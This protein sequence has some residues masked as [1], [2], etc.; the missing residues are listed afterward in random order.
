L[1]KLRL[2]LTAD[3]KNQN[4]HDWLVLDQSGRLIRQGK[5][6]LSELPVC[7]ETEV[8]IPTHLVNFINVNLP[9]ATG[10]KLD[11][12][13]PFIVEE[14]ILSN[15]D[16]VHVIIGSRN[17]DRATL[18]IVQKFWMKEFMA[19]LSSAKIQVKRMFPDCL[20][21]SLRND[22]WT[23]AQQETTLLVRTGQID[24]FALNLANSDV[25]VAYNFLQMALKEKNQPTKSI[26][27][28]AYGELSETL[29]EWESNL[30]A[31][32]GEMIEGE[33]RSNKLLAPLNLLQKDFLGSNDFVQR[34]YHFKGCA[35]LAIFILILHFCFTLVEVGLQY[36][37]V[38]QIN[39][40]M[41]S[42]FKSSFPDTTAIVDAPLQMQRKL[43]EANHALGEVSNSD[44]QP[45]LA[46]ISEIIGSIPSENLIS[47]AYQ[48]HKIM[49]M[50]RV[51]SMD[52]AEAVRKKLVDG[53]LMVTLGQGRTND[54]LTDIQ[55]LISR[56]IK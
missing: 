24:G 8:V 17:G 10:K 7:T 42:L 29:K 23:L 45:L 43:Q 25:Q 44:Y 18:V 3:F 47:M 1:S 40:Q 14:Y 28:R 21:L 35:I 55:L 16:D 27:L 11:L 48:D 37:K 51:Q 20:L 36:Q 9:D 49:L 50:F 54:A 13:L 31:H 4:L 2:F 30:G 26:T 46:S 34:L 32:V 53:G 22:S 15:P 12:M 38:H 56:G 5:S 52:Q 41:T 39:H 33:W 19:T 6:A